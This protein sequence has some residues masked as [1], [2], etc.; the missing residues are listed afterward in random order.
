MDIQLLGGL[1]VTRTSQQG[2]LDPSLRCLFIYRVIETTPSM[3]S[4]TNTSIYFG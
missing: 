2:A 3:D 1:A 4:K